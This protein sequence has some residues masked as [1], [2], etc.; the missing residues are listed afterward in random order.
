MLYLILLCFAIGSR[1]GFVCPI[2]APKQ[3]GGTGTSSQWTDAKT[4]EEAKAAAEANAAVE[5]K[6][7][8]DAKENVSVEREPQL[9]QDIVLFRKC[10]R[11]ACHRDRGSIRRGNQRDSLRYR[12]WSAQGGGGCTKPQS[13]R[14]Q[15]QQ[16]TPKSCWTNC[17][18]CSSWLPRRIE[19]LSQWQAF[20]EHFQKNLC[21]ETAG[22]PAPH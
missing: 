21:P 4:A 16:F 10:S 12:D 7:A 8:A 14:G 22:V 13:S 19:P 17:H 20:L 3:T 5:A 6:A 15:G 1:G 18:S 11:K 9:S 2:A